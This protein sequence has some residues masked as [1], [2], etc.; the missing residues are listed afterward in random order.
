MAGTLD[1][2]TGLTI[3][4]HIFVAEKGYYYEIAD[5]KPQFAER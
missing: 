1:G 3:S 2:E 4:R 5:G